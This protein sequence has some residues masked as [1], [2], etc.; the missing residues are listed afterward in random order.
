MTCVVVTHSWVSTQCVIR[1][2]MGRVDK[3][4][5]IT[6]DVLCRCPETG[7]VD[8]NRSQ[9][10]QS[11]LQCVFP[12]SSHMIWSY[13]MRPCRFLPQRQRRL[14]S[15]T[16]VSIIQQHVSQVQ[17]KQESKWVCSFLFRIWF[18]IWLSSC[19]LEHIHNETFHTF[20]IRFSARGTGNRLKGGSHAFFLHSFGCD[21]SLWTQGFGSGFWQHWSVL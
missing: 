9:T 15:F 16:G 19:H 3:R 17:I 7:G 10:Y 2:W 18:Y 8:N 1:S 21:H 6:S 20:L 5:P 4:G 13:V 14:T 11:S 12:W